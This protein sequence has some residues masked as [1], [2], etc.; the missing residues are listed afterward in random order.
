MD[1]VS[2]LYFGR[3]DAESD[4]AEGLLRDGFLPTA[5]FEA[6]R[7]GKKFLII[8]RKGAGKSAICMRMVGEPAAYLI[9]P[10]DAA[11]D[12]LRRFELQ[13]VNDETAKSFIWRYVF[14]VQ[15]ARH[16]VAHAKTGHRRWFL[17]RPVRALRRFLTANHEL[18]GGSFYDR[19]LKGVSGLQ[20]SI[21][22][23]AFGFKLSADSEGKAASEGARANRQ[24][25]IIEQGVTNAVEALGCR[26]H[27]GVTL[28]V[29]QVEQIWSNDRDSD[30]MVIG[31]L[32][33][34]KRLHSVLPGIA[35]CV[36][37]LRADI[38]DVL[39]FGDGDKFHGDE[40]RI[41]WSD[42]RLCELMLTRA[43]VSL[44]GDLTDEKFWTEVMPAPSAKAYVL[45][46]VL[47][48]PR[49]IIQ[50]LNAARDVAYGKGETSISQASLLEAELTFSQWKLQD[51]A[52][53]YAVTYPYLDRLFLIFQSGGFLVSRATIAERFAPLQAAL[54]EQFGGFVNVLNPDS[55]V[56]TLYSVGLLGVRRNSS[57]HYAGISHMGLQPHENV[58]EVHPCFRAALN[59]SY[60]AQ[61]MP[62][63]G[64]IGPVQGVQVGTHNSQANYFGQEYVAASRP[65]RDRSLV[66]SVWR[67]YDR[68]RARVGRASIPEETREEIKR[69]LAEMSVATDDLS[70]SVA[71]VQDVTEHT[72]RAADVFDELAGELKSSGLEEAF[73]DEARRLRGEVRGSL[74]G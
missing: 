32:L 58:F 51:L 22:L 68:L 38:Y 36:L 52:K 4:M 23:E 8:G 2:R 3:D 6:A 25:D 42:D 64:A 17:P 20:G 59:A 67:A 70:Q 55:V 63:I 24:L 13:G 30:T 61:P 54:H 47:P 46:R 50:F 40:F 71:S 28:L 35:R 10:D 29:D 19:L 72:Y 27:P 37:F 15:I 9:T 7:T 49:D 12:E 31:L 21:S 16:I 44:G 34:A 60:A 26:S 48:R 18:D 74:P 41:D 39:H 43:R 11:G 33:A 56:D 1:F 62:R 66:E 53:E 14:L 65:G 57:V 45:Q 73:R 5:A 69:R